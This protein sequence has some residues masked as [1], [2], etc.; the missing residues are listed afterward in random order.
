MEQRR[1]ICETINSIKDKI[2]EGEL[3]EEMVGVIG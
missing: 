3:G 1:T 2:P